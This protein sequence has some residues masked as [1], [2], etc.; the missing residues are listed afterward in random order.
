MTKYRKRDE[1]QAEQREAEAK[2][3]NLLYRRTSLNKALGM[4]AR[5]PYAF[6]LS[7][8]ELAQAETLQSLTEEQLT[9]VAG[10]VG[11]NSRPLWIDIVM[12]VAA[13]VFGAAVTFLT[14]WHF[15]R[16]KAQAAEAWKSRSG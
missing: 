10:V 2:A 14:A 3:S 4:S 9:A 8:E 6:Q 12:V 16:R 13:A 5:N 11:S 7:E 15:S 1:A